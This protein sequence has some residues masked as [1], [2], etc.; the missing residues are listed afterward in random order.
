EGIRAIR[1]D[2]RGCGRGAHLSRRTYNG[3]CSHDVR[4]AVE[5][6]LREFDTSPLA[7]IGFSLG[8]N[9][10]LKLAGE[11]VDA[12]LPQLACVAAVAP[13]I[14]LVQCAALIS[15]PRNRLYE[16]HFV[17][18]M[19]KQVRLHQR[20]FPELPML[21]IPLHATLRQFDDL[22]T[23]P[24]GGFSGALDYY[25]RA[26]SFPLV[27]RIGVPALI[28]T[29]RVDPF[30]AVEP[31]EELRAPSHIEVQISRHGGHLGF[32]GWDHT[33]SVRWAERRVVDWVIQKLT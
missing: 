13:P 24:R 19:I 25:R 27:P 11:A 2:L 21:R 29:P 1:M 4:A 14:D 18:S 28:L 5:E 7:L 9:I 33:G 16:M 12:P 10:A 26:S 20:H 15:A 32:I 31:F 22:Y 17:R 23:A 8:G 6:I 30:I 3:A